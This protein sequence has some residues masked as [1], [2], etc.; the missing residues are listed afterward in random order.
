MGGVFSLLR[1]PPFRSCFRT[2]KTTQQ[3]MR[4]PLP[5]HQIRTRKKNLQESRNRGTDPREAV[6]KGHEFGESY[7]RE[8]TRREQSRPRGR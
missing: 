1:V 5:T 2:P 8:P 3:S 7:R 6:G 4:A